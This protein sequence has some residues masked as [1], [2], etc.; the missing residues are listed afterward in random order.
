MAWGL[1][2][3]FLKANRVPEGVASYSGVVTLVLGTRF[4]PDW[5]PA[6][7]TAPK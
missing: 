1:Y 4:S 6:S 5:I 2:D 3:R 7:K